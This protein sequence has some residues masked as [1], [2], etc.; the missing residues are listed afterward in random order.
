MQLKLDELIRASE[1]AHNA[2]LDIE[3]LSEEELDLIKARYQQLAQ[4]ARKNLRDGRSD[5][6]Q[7]EFSHRG[8]A[9]YYQR[10]HALVRERTHAGGVSQPPHS[11]GMDQK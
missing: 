8:R 4:R 2:L 11:K 5:L 1:A 9:N 6:G 10:R 7:P 3:E